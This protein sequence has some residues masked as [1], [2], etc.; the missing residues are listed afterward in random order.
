M[1]SSATPAALA[2]A[3]VDA[4]NAADEAGLLGLFAEGAILHHPTG[5]FEGKPAIAA[6]Y[7]DVVIAGQTALTLGRVLSGEPEGPDDA[8]TMVV[9]ELVATSRLLG[10]GDAPLHSVDVA[11][12]DPDGRIAVFD[13]YYR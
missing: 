9:F 10:E 11:S 3:Y 8:E 13:V 1:T 5:V 7:R 6:F 12:L 2:R 4:V